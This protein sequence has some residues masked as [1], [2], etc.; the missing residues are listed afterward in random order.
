VLRTLDGRALTDETGKPL[1]DAPKVEDLLIHSEQ[2]LDRLRGL[3]GI[4]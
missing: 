4:A 3:A 2:E 1:K